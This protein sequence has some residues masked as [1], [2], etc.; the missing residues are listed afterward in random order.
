MEHKFS[1]EK[2]M[3]LV[4]LINTVGSR[5]QGGKPG[6]NLSK[7]HLWEHTSLLRVPGKVVNQRADF[8]EE[9]L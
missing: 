7:G 8:M 2:G 6:S 4:L 9:T 5:L 3:C 1:V